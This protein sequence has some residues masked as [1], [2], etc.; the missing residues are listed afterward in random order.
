MESGFKFIR[1]FNELQSA[2][3]LAG[4]IDFPQMVVVGG[5]SDGK[6]SLLESIVGRNFLPRGD[7]IVTRTPIILQLNYVEQGSSIFTTVHGFSATLI[8]NF[9]IK[10]GL[11]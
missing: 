9:Q 6:S 1:K 3:N 2:A 7:G 10:S 11:K 4:K 8:Y 5:Q